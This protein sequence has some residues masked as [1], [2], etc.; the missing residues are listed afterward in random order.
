MQPEADGRLGGDV[1]YFFV[2]IQENQKERY[3]VLLNCI[4][5]VAAARVVR[6]TWAG[7]SA[8]RRSR[9]DEYQSTTCC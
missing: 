3:S 6:S 7:V 4:A 9:R 2:M 5:T 8:T 1:V